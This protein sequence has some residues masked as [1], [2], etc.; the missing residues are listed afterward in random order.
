[1]TNF[2][3]PSKMLFAALLIACALFPFGAKAA[4]I[5]YFYQNG[6]NVDATGVGTINTAGLTYS[7]THVQS[8]AV[9]P[10]FAFEITGPTTTQVNNAWTGITGPGSF[11][12]GSV[13]TFA[14]SGSGDSVGIAGSVDGLYLPQ[15][16]TSGAP[17]S[18]SSVYDSTTISTLGLTPGT[19]TYNFGTGLT[20]DTFTV[21]IG[22]A[23][24][25][26]VPEPTTF[27]LFTLAALAST[28]FLLRKRKHAAPR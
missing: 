24:P 23:P 20:A 11:G 9:L 28:L 4:Y 6:A 21:I 2:L 22:T 14:D 3:R 15:N 26:S 16:Y 7:S 27:V 25:A 10:Q 19:Y 12:P 13:G 1:M 18:D 8:A 5:V 17:L